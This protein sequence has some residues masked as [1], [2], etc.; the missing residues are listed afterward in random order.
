[1][2][3]DKSES[4]VNLRFL[5]VETG[6]KDLSLVSR[7]SSREADPAFEE[8]KYIHSLFSGFWVNPIVGEP[9]EKIASTR[10]KKV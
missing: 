3:L 4:K 9:I 7:C 8:S 6:A 1:L 2:L 5:A 10:K